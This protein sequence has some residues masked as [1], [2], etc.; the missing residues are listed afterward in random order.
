VLLPCCAAQFPSIF[1]PGTAFASRVS[2]NFTM[3]SL[4]RS[5]LREHLGETLRA[6]VEVLANASPQ[7]RR[8][9]VGSATLLLQL[10]QYVKH[11][12]LLARQA[13]AD[14]GYPVVVHRRAV[15]KVHSAIVCPWCGRRSESGNAFEGM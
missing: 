4:P 5:E 2:R 6:D 12:A 11:N 7:Q 10:M 1:S 13:V 14:I 8:R 3:C 9:D 15:Y